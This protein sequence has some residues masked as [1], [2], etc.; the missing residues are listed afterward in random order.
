MRYKRFSILVGLFL[1]LACV[2]TLSYAQVS[3]T[4]QLHLKW[5]GVM[6]ERYGSDTLA[7]ISL[8]SA[9]YETAMPVFCQSFPIYDSHVKVQVELGKVVTAP[10][11]QEEMRLAETYTFEPDFELKA[12]RFARSMPRI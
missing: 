3:S 7:Y 11:S 9:E 6:Q 5:K 12:T 4:H 8:E 2:S 1:C 10:L